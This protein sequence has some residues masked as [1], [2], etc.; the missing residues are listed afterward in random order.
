MTLSFYRLYTFHLQ[1]DALFFA[2]LEQCWLATGEKCKESLLHK[3]PARP[4]KLVEAILMK[5]RGTFIA[6]P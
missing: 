4:A 5:G 1:P 3:R 6:S 2:S